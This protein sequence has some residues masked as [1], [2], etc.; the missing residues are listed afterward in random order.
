MPDI[1]ID[2]PGTQFRRAYLLYVIEVTRNGDAYFYVGQTGDNNYVTARP[3]FRR[4]AGHLEDV[5]QST[6]NQVYRFIATEVLGHG[7]ARGRTTFSETVKQSVEDFLASASIAMHIYRVCPFDPKVER[8]EHRAIV[9]EVSRLEQRVIAAF[10]GAG[11][12]LM[13]KR[14]IS[15]PAD[16]PHSDVLVRIRADFGL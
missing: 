2:L 4:L 1:R 16:G 8:A 5:G 7:D 10:Q 11:K 13:N 3:P 6:Q 14:F 9:W 15:V 12:R